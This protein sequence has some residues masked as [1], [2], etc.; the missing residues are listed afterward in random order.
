M[1]LFEVAREQPVEP[2][3]GLLL[4]ASRRSHATSE[5]HLTLEVLGRNE[6]LVFIFAQ[7]VENG[8][9]KA[10]GVLGVGLHVA[11]DHLDG[12][13]LLR[14]VPAVVVGAHANHLVCDLGLLRELGFG[15]RAHVDDTAAPRAV[16]VRFSAGAELGSLHADDSALVVQAHAVALEAVATLAHNLGDTLVEGVRETDVADHTA[17]EEGERT[18]ALG[19]VDDLVGDDKVAGLD[20]FLQRAYGAEG[21]DGADTE[22]AE[23]SDV[24]AGG[25]LVRSDLVVE[26][27]AGDEGDGDGLAVGRGRGVVED[28]DGRGGSAPGSGELEGGDGCEA[29]EGLEAGATD[30]RNGDGAWKCC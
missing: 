20:L 23:S 25:H 24:G 10:P 21:N 19:A 30:H 27:M 14:R 26:T 11:H 8:T 4:P 7:L 16:H 18:D 15:K 22:A 6:I 12:H 28:G 3:L 9:D 17:L 5:L 29:R 13:A 1:N 2:L